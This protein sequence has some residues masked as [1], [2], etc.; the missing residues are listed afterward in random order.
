MLS[1]GYFELDANSDICDQNKQMIETI[2][3]AK[4]SILIIFAIF[5]LSR[6]SGITLELA[7]CVLLE[8]NAS[9]LVVF[10]EFNVLLE[11]DSVELVVCV[12]LLKFVST[13]FL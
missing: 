7:D 13:G 1:P 5:F 4:A 8:L 2:T 11:L 6:G 12:L 3:T 9:E 10:V